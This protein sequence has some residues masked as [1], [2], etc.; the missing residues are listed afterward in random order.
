MSKDLTKKINNYLKDFKHNIRVYKK[1]KFLPCFI[2]GLP[3][4]GSTLLHQIMITMFDFNY[5][6][7]IKGFFYQNI[8]IGNLLHNQF[9]KENNYES[10]FVSK[11]GNTNGPLEPSEWGWFWRKWL[12]LK[13]NEHHISR[14]VDWV[15]LK[16]ELLTIE[17]MNSSPLLFDTPFIN[18]NL[19]KFINNIGPVIIFDLE[20]SHSA[21]FKSLLNARIQKYGTLKKY[22]GAMTR[23][24][25]ILRIQNPY[26]QVFKQVK[27]LNLEKK[28]MLQS[29]PKDLV[30]KIHYEN[31]IK[32]PMKEMKKIKRFFGRKKIKINL[33]KIV[34][35]KFINRNN[36]PPKF[37]TSEYDFTKYSQ[38]LQN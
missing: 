21:I 19:D 38:Q 28:N 31:L 35:P 16:K 33:K 24:K 8:I 6:S 11:F 34:L 12:N 14:N 15:N 1:F 23:E 29:I 17:S 5:V 30:L 26:A 22:Y 25:K 10:N 20:R 18:G 2:F 4:S 37:S 9:V 32:Q 3:R 27:Q 36:N 13:N 7:N